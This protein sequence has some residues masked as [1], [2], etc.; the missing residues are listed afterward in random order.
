MK[1]KFSMILTTALF[2]ALS[3]AFMVSCLQDPDDPVAAKTGFVT[4]NLSTKSTAARTALP[5]PTFTSYKLV[6]ASEGGGG[7]REFTFDESE[8]TN[9][10]EIAVGGYT[11]TVY[12]YDTGKANITASNHIANGTSESFQVTAGGATDVF[13]PMTFKTPTGTEKGTLTYKITNNS[14]ILTPSVDILITP[15]AGGEP[16]DKSDNEGS[17]SDIPAGQYYVSVTLKG[18]GL[19]AIKGDIV[20]IYSKQTTPFNLTFADA[21]FH[22]DIEAIWL[23]GDM[24]DWDPQGVA[25]TKEFG[26]FTWEGDIEAN[27]SFRFHLTD[28][29]GYGDKW[30]GDWFVSSLD[31]AEVVIT[32]NALTPMEF[33]NGN[34]QNNWKVESAGYYIIE[35]GPYIKKV[36]IKLAEGVTNVTINEGNVQLPQGGTKTF[37]A[38]VEGYNSP[39]QTVTWSVSGAQKAG[40][41]INATSGV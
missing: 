12:G 39:V 33:V 25:M 16:I 38:T 11:L 7:T 3:A 32:P 40:T 23:V 37:T 8:W 29:S 30:Y 17:V 26:V 27:E 4:I 10:V 31:Q 36:L 34:Y 41:A 28:V 24:A 35:V 9:P 2:S 1:N 13:V 6:F 22:T 14:G 5:T 21:D 18:D 19:I 20:H 15:Y